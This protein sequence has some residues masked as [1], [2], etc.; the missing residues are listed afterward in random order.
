MKRRR[1]Q[2]WAG[3]SIRGRLTEQW[4]S[5]NATPVRPLR[6]HVWDVSV[7]DEATQDQRTRQNEPARSTRRNNDQEERTDQAWGSPRGPVMPFC[8]AVGILGLFSLSHPPIP[9]FPS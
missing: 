3:R 9:D 2:S 4:W 5:S 7:P 8:Q 1:R 6:V